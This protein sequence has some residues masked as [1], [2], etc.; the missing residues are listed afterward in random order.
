MSTIKYVQACRDC[1]RCDGINRH[2]TDFERNPK[3]KLRDYLTEFEIMESIEDWLDDNDIVCDFCESNNLDIIDIELDNQKLYD[4]NK[5]DNYCTN[6]NT[7]FFILNLSKTVNQIEIKTGGKRFI[8]K[9]LQT[10]F[11]KKIINTVQTRPNK[12]FYEQLKGSFFICVSG[13]KDS[14]SLDEIII[15]SYTTAGLSRQEIY[16][17]LNTI[18]NQLGVNLDEMIGEKKSNN[19]LSSKTFKGSM[20]VAFMYFEEEEIEDGYPFSCAYF[21]LNENTIIAFDTSETSPSDFMQNNQN[22]IF[23]IDGFK[24]SLKKNGKNILFTKKIKQ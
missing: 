24:I 4:F 15:E 19:S 6:N 1:F 2:L 18:A 17:S 10:N 14:M 7:S 22:E 20:F 3:L 11:Y 16:D 5:L 9:I 8:E 21:E 13:K 12:D 23:A